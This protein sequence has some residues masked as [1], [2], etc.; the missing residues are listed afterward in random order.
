MP[1][2]AGPLSFTCLEAVADPRLDRNKRHKLVDILV[3]ALCGFLA[4]CEGWVDVEMF[5]KAKRKWLGQFLE[6]PHGIPSHDTFGRVFALLDPRQ[7]A[8][9]LR[10][11]VHTVLPSLAGQAVAIDGKTLRG[12]GQQTTA[13]QALHL[14]SAWATERGV[15]LGQ[16]PTADHSNE[17]TAI[18]G[19]L[20]LL[21]LRGATVTID[22]MGC[23]KEIACQLRQQ[24]ADYVLAVKDNQKNLAEA[25]DLQLRRTYALG[26]SRS[27]CTTHEKGHGRTDERTYTAMAAPTPVQQQWPDA[28]SIVRVC[29]VTTDAQ[30]KKTKEVRDFVSSLPAEVE[31]LAAAIRGHWGIENGLH[32]S[33]DVTFG[34]DDSRIRVGHG[35]ENSALLRRLALSIVKQVTQYSNSLRGKRLRAGW[36]TG[37]LEHFLMIFAGN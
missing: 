33:L 12:S 1:W 10:Q 6:L 21:D 24:G 32:W 37:V 27:K 34:E 13:R 3:I 19:L 26:V 14:V 18:P 11:F 5:G 20:R 36:E 28:Q 7:L 25:L 8:P 22:A 29:R 2:P 16:V 35:P 23:Q 4:G 31:R 17:I 9:V 15:V 30:G